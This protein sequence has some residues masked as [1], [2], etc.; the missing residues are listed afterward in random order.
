MKAQGRRQV[1]WHVGVLGLEMGL[2]KSVDAGCSDESS[3]ASA[4][5]RYR[6]PAATGSFLADILLFLN[7]IPLR[8]PG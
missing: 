8:T 1:G 2:Q 3:L 5:R 4:A 7:I 6:G